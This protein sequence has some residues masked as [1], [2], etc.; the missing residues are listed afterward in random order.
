M[1]LVRRL[2]L[3][4][5]PAIASADRFAEELNSALSTGTIAA[6]QLRLKSANDESI[7]RFA[8][9]LAGVCAAADVAFILNDRPDLAAELGCDGVHI[10]QA[11][12]TL[13][14]ARRL[15]GPERV[16]GVSCHGSRHLAM[17]AAE[18]GADYVA[19]GAFFPSPT[20]PTAVRCDPEVLSIWRETTTIP[21]VA[22]GGVSAENCAALL[23]AG[24]DFLAVSSGIWSHPNGPAWA[25]RAFSAAIAGAQTASTG[26]DLAS[27]P[28]LI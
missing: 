13:R 19:F 25:V 27:N 5:P 14:E 15:V 2:Y 18:G 9:R 17:E 22:I 23:V 20:K 12:G 1:A 4:S 24:A 21:S 10:G 16:V 28:T 11:D 3:V 6:F 7:A 8:K 26:G